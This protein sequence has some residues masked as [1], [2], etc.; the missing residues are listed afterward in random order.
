MVSRKNFEKNVVGKIWIFCQNSQLFLESSSTSTF[1]SA[2]SID[3]N[4]KKRSA[5]GATLPPPQ[6]HHRE[7][8]LLFSEKRYF[9]DFCP[10]DRN[11]VL[12]LLLIYATKFQTW[13]GARARTFSD[14]G[15]F[16]EILCFHEKVLFFLC[17]FCSKCSKE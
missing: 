11:L 4:L 16:W 6:V 8:C 7:K 15:S 2:L 14:L 13:S 3:K 17:F 10:C 12:A 1:L 9:P 5:R